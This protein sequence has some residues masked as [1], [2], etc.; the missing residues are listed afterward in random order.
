MRR[1]LSLQR[2]APGQGGGSR[3]GRSPGGISTHRHK[4]SH[5]SACAY[6]LGAGQ[7]EEQ[8]QRRLGEVQVLLHAKAHLQG[9]E[10]GWQDGEPAGHLQPRVPVLIHLTQLL[11]QVQAQDTD[12]LGPG[13]EMVRGKEVVPG[14]AE[15][16]RSPTPRGALTA[17]LL[18]P[19]KWPLLLSRSSL[20]C[21]AAQWLFTLNGHEPPRVIRTAL[22]HTHIYE[23]SLKSTYLY[24]LQ[25][26]LFSSTFYS[27]LFRKC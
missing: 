5:S 24:P 26:K 17:R 14:E 3:A 8:V 11:G 23:F 19:P 13:A 7:R 12:L 25:S 20:L 16:H 9:G 6:L 1:T 4:T 27:S 10:E 21:S 18:S 22:Q 2:P 15:R